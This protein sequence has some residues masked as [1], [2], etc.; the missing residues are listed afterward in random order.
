MKIQSA[1]KIL[2][3]L[4]IIFIS[5]QCRTQNHLS[6][7][8]SFPVLPKEYKWP[9]KNDQQEILKFFTSVAL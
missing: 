1:L 5:L 2:S 8:T 4:L 7:E 3:T 9:S 6:V